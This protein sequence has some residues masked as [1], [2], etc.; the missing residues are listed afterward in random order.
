MSATRVPTGSARLP[1][2]TLFR[3]DA[4]FVLQGGGEFDRVDGGASGVEEVGVGGEVPA[5]QEAA[6]HRGDGGAQVVGGVRGGRG[7]GRGVGGGRR[8]CVRR[9]GGGAG[10][11]RRGSGW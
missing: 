10:D 8:L 6:G 2:T 4:E 1:Y 3:A 7:R 11:L 5:G 9:G